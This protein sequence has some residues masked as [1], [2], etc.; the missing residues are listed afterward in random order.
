MIPAPHH[1]GTLPGYTGTRV[2][3]YSGTRVH[4]SIYPG[5]R[6]PGYRVPGSPGIRTHSA[7]GSRTVRN[8][9][10]SRKN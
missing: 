2:P 6:V 9:S 10:Q 7:K 3:G 1:W 8:A 4:G 5:T